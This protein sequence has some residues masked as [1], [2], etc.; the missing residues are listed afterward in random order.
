MIACS[1]DFLI[2]NNLLKLKPNMLGL[3][4]IPQNVSFSVMCH[5]LLS[6]NY[7]LATTSH[8][9]HKSIYCPLRHLVPLSLKGGLQVISGVPSDYVFEPLHGSSDYPV[10]L[11]RDSDLKEVHSPAGVP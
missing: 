10:D 1:R 6:I 8:S 9:V 2:S 7:S 11:L 4:G 3:L 5:V